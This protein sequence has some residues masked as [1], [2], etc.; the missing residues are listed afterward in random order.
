MIPATD[1]AELAPVFQRLLAEA[2]GHPGEWWAS[3]LE[4]GWK[5]SVLC[6]GDH[7]HAIRFRAVQVPTL[8]WIEFLAE[9]SRLARLL[10][11]GAW[12]LEESDR[13]LFFEASFIA[14]AD[15]PVITQGDAHEGPD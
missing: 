15:T 13:R 1:E 3:V 5:F 7:R 10:G 11:L 9:A 6:R 14:P 4:S 12:K 8:A 2:C